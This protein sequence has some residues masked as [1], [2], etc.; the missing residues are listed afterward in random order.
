M[1]IEVVFKYKDKE[2]IINYDRPRK[3]KEICEEFATKQ[4]L[5]MNDI[6]F[7]YK[8]EKVNLNTELYLEQQFNLKN[9]TRIEFLVIRETPF[10]II[11]LYSG[12]TMILKV[13]ETEKMKDIFKRFTKKARID[14]TKI[15]FL[16]KGNEYNYNNIGE[17]TVGEIIG[18]ENDI[19]RREQLMSIPVKGLRN[20]TINSI[21]EMENPLI[22]NDNNSDNIINEDEE[23]HLLILEDNI[24]NLNI[25]RSI[26]WFHFI[27]FIILFSQFSFIMLLSII[28]FNSKFNEIIIK[29]DFSL[30]IKYIPIIAFITLLAFIFILFLFEHRKKK[31]I[32][33]FHVAY[34]FFIFYYC[35]LFSD[36][37]DTK[38]I[39]IGLSLLEMEIL[40]VLINIFA[41]KFK[42]L[43]ICLSALL[44][45]LIGLI[46]FSAFWIK[47]LYPIIFVSIYWLVS[48]GY[49]TFWIYGKNTL[50]EI[51]EYFYSVL[52]FNYSIFLC[53]VYSIVYLVE[54]IC[55]YLKNRFNDDNIEL[56]RRRDFYL[57]NLIILF[58]QFA[59]I[60]TLTVIGFKY[61][62]DEIL[63]K[64]DYSLE[65]KYIPI[66][67][68]I[69]LL[70][71]IFYTCLFDYNISK[72][73][74]IFHVLYP[75]FICYCSFMLSEYLDSKY[76]IIGLCLFGIEILSI[77]INIFSKKYEILYIGLS[78][79]IL[80]LIGLIFFSAFWIKS[81]YPIIFVSIFWL[82]SNGCYTLLIFIINKKCE[83]YEHFYST[84]IF[85]YSIFLGLAY[86]I[87]E[88]AKY[89]K[90]RFDD[91]DNELQRIRK[92][93]FMN[94]IILF[95]QFAVIIT[96]TIIGFI[97][98]FNEILIQFD[99]SLI[100]K[101]TPFI[102][103]MFFM[104]LIYYICAFV[105]DYTKNTGLF[106][107][108]LFFPPFICYYSFL[109]SEFIDSKY[110]I[111]ALG[112]IGIEILSLLINIIL[113]KFE[114]L[115]IC[116]S[117][118]ILSLIG[119][120]IF[121]V[122][123]IKSFHPIVY[124]SI[125]W[126]LSNGYYTLLIF[127]TKKLCEL[128]EYFYSVI[129]II[130][131]YNI[132]L[133]IISGI[134]YIYKKIEEPDEERLKTQIKTFGIILFQYILITTVVWIGFSFEWN[135]NI[136]ENEE[137]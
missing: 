112:L 134:G 20:D 48:N 81:L 73:I 124:I 33:I 110:I 46:L 116:L 84:I 111:I 93:Y 113:K 127:V 11:F 137:T 74:I 135:K 49:Y 118:L 47:S 123:W 66:L 133:G 115:Y 22:D 132:Y 37:L 3:L 107:F 75:P 52:I 69:F 114:F 83:L 80:S 97:Y 18:N 6:F 103:F 38:Y 126:L 12:K 98:K 125:F 82:V 121:S 24:R 10:Q 44:T 78:A 130:F 129:A 70:M 122:F 34:P 41:K 28:A 71:F 65:I 35:L 59:V 4:S 94:F 106:I 99:A 68:F 90:S 67:V 36:F 13:K 42:N 15:F 26:R 102:C 17:I 5:D 119:L 54:C 87:V 23:E 72:I 100:V 77:L 51:D 62:F 40:S 1:M 60:I 88:S 31:L 96:L 117:A 56:K 58:I 29:A 53:L 136:K 86:I 92:F 105:F 7:T 91:N 57:N 95:I 30:E 131:N 108:Y 109:L 39:I 76:I 120:I 8:Y 79:V 25:Q 9:K 61:K 85:N 55:Y 64:A 32:I 101:Y 19:D 45:S 14:L 104:A 16:Y 2:F 63:I 27:N 50:Y 21:P 43:Y 89:I 128:D